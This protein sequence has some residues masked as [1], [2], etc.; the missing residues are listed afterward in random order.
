MKTDEDSS[1]QRARNNSQLGVKVW[2][3]SQRLT[4]HNHIVFKNHMRP[5]QWTMI[6]RI[7]FLKVLLNHIWQHGDHL[8][9]KTHLWVV[10][11]TT[12]PCFG[13]RK[14]S[15]NWPLKNWHK[16]VGVVYCKVSKN[17]VC[18]SQLLQNP[19][20]RWDHSILCLPNSLSLHYA[21]WSFPLDAQR[22]PYL[23]I[24]LQNHPP[25]GWAGQGAIHTGQ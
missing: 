10:V 17:E 6:L 12:I 16:E 8:V 20:T 3:E 25:L 21:F 14:S 11:V 5:T 19:T 1:P 7:D 15:P 9:E 2:A 24:L 22:V 13:I 4:K 23:C 18:I